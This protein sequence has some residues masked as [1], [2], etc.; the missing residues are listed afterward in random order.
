MKNSIAISALLT[1]SKVN[2]HNKQ[3]VAYP[4]S[5]LETGNPDLDNR[6]LE[7][8]FVELGLDA[9]NVIEEEA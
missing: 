1:V 7:A 8:D 4:Q 9:L 5:L 3:P 2:S 6:N